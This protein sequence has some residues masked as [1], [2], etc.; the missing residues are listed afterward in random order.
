MAWT[1]W[2]GEYEVLQEYKTSGSVCIQ[3]HGCGFSTL[4]VVTGPHRGT[5]WFDAR[6]TCDLILPLM[7][8]GRHLSFAD[9]IGRRSMDL[10]DR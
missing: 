4:L 2:D 9:R 3:E 10:V 5:M 1:A 7:L 8:D 6:A